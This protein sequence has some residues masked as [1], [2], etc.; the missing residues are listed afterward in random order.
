M[1]LTKTSYEHRDCSDAH[2]LIAKAG[3]PEDLRDRV[4]FLPL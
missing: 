4:E 3:E 1:V 2:Q